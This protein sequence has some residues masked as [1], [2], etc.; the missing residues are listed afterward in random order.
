M[1]QLLILVGR[2]LALGFR[3]HREL[4]LEN[5][6]PSTAAD[7]DAADERSPALAGA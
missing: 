1:L 4:V 3:G 5:L 6:A 7:R 2:A